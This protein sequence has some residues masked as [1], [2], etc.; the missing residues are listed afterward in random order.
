MQYLVEGRRGSLPTSPEL[1]VSFLE[2]IVIPHFEH[3]IKLERDKI[4]L[5]GGL[6]VGDRAFV[7]II[8]AKDND[9]A[10]RIV[11]GTPGWPIL[12]WTITPLQSVAS[13]AEMEREFVKTLK[14]G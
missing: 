14:A 5:G 1:A 12:E 10:D 9:E 4:I 2:G 8:E 7:F 3:L 6:P 13:R 11:R